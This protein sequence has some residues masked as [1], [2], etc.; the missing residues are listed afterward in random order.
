[1]DKGR[2]RDTGCADGGRDKGRER[3]I[4]CRGQCAVEGMGILRTS[5]LPVFIFAWVFGFPA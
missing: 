2:E 5:I 4:G 3:D 1:M